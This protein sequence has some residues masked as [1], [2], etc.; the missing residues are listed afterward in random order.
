MHEESILD[1]ME[2]VIRFSSSVTSSVSSMSSIRSVS[3]ID[4]ACSSPVNIVLDSDTQHL[5]HDSQEPESSSFHVN[6]DSIDRSL[7]ESLV[8]SALLDL[9]STSDDKSG[10][11]NNHSSSLNAGNLVNK[12]V[13]P[14]HVLM[15]S[16]GSL[17]GTVKNNVQGQ[18]VL[19]LQTGIELLLS[20]SNYL[21]LSSPV[22]FSPT[23]NA[24]TSV[25]VPNNRFTVLRTN[26]KL[27][28]GLRSS[29]HDGNNSM[30][31]HLVMI[32]GN[33]RNTIP[34][35]AL[36]SQVIDNN[37]LY[38]IMSTY[39]N[40]KMDVDDMRRVI[41]G[42]SFY[43]T[44]AL[45][46]TA[47][48]INTLSPSAKK[49]GR[50]KLCSTDGWSDGSGSGESS[51]QGRSNPIKEF[52]QRQRTRERQED[53]RLYS[54]EQRYLKSRF[55][56]LPESLDELY[57]SR[58]MNIKFPRVKT[59]F[60]RGKASDDNERSDR[61]KECARRDSKNYRERAKAKRDLVVKKI[62]FLEDLFTRATIAK[63][64]FVFK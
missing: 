55:P 49:R 53:E 33:N 12:N 36:P 27:E 14:S 44:S 39:V 6:N 59:L 7:E 50:K 43:Q 2:S 21:P 62:H 29:L 51:S 26:S 40:P 48:G 32:P 8:A 64:Q 17:A 23:S 5:R 46:S 54:L 20:S 34:V 57:D 19:Q 61:K 41:P 18:K 37:S 47:N 10:V 28:D 25:I 63:Y 45:S 52:R 4:S 16:D 9:A 24:S 13:A 38:Q 42:S 11:V 22:S 1:I 35:N 60:K 30:S 56:D 31:S 3:S 58:G 15:K